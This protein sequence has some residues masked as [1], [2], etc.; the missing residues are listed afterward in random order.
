M[1]DW[2]RS[3]KRETGSGRWM[4][5]GT[6]RRRGGRLRLKARGRLVLWELSGESKQILRSGGSGRKENRIGMRNRPWVQQGPGQ[7]MNGGLKLGRDRAGSHC[8]QEWLGSSHP[9][10]LHQPQWDVLSAHEQHLL[11]LLVHVKKPALPIGIDSKPTVV[12]GG[13]PSGIMI[14]GFVVVGFFG[15]FLVYFLEDGTDESLANLKCFESSGHGRLF[16]IVLCIAVKPQVTT[17]HQLLIKSSTHGLCSP[18][19]FLFPPLF[20]ELMSVCG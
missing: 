14:W 8:H 7:C 17:S 9:P 15:V 2:T 3:C 4:F 6:L 10:T 12:L 5:G 1:V 18:L 16:Q 11:H 19:P 20:L 13:Y